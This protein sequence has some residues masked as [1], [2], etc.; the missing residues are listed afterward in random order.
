MQMTPRR[1]AMID[2]HL[3]DTRRMMADYAFELN[4]LV[5]Y[6]LSAAQDKATKRYHP[7]DPVNDAIRQWEGFDRRLAK[8][9]AQ[10]SATRQRLGVAPFDPEGP[11]EADP[12]P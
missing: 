5:R 10:V 9:A 4:D 8:L 7:M 6:A 2:A 12:A 11:V 3:A 1:Q